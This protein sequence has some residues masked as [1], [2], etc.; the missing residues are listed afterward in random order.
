MS[1][2]RKRRE[3]LPADTFAPTPVRKYGK[4]VMM[5]CQVRAPRG[6]VGRPLCNRG[7]KHDGRHMT[8]TGAF[9][10]NEEENQ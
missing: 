3:L 2:F 8:L 7:Y 5:H 1:W 10:D 4:T 9:W 6:V